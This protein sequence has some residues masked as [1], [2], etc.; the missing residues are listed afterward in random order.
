M[1]LLEHPAITDAIITSV[2][3]EEVKARN[4]SAYQRLRALI[5]SDL[6][7]FYV[8]A[9]EY[10]RDTY[11]TADPGESPNDRNDRAIRVAAAW[12]VNKI[13]SMK[14]LLLSDDAHNRT[15]AKELGVTAV[16]SHEYAAMRHKDAP[17]LIDLVAANKQADIEMLDKDSNITSSSSKQKKQ[18]QGQKIY[19]PHL[20]ISDIMMG[21]KSGR[22]HQGSLRV[23]RF[24]RYDGWVSSDSI[25]KDILI[26][27]RVSMNR[28]MDGDVVAI[29]ILPED[30]WHSMVSTGSIPG[31]DTS[32]IADTDDINDDNEDGE[33]IGRDSEVHLAPEIDV[34]ASNVDPQSNGEAARRPTG[35][36]VGIVKRNWRSRGY[37]GSLK[38]PKNDGTS[39]SFSDGSH[40]SVL[41]IPVE[42]RF[43]PIR[44]S[45][46]QAGTLADKRFI[47]VVDGW[48]E[49][50]YHPL[51]HYVRTLGC[52]GDV[53]V[54]TEVLLIENDV[55]TSPFS[56][57]VHA[58]VPPLPWTVTDR[59]IADPARE[60]LRH[61]AVCSVDPPGCKDIDDA[62]HL[63]ELPNGNYELGVH[64]A[65]VSHFV[66]PGTAMDSEAATRATTTYL[67][68]RRIDML[69]KPLTED[70][71]SLRSGMER[72]AFSVIWEITPDA[73]VLNTRFTKSVIC[74]RAALTYQEAQAR[75]DDQRLHDE[76]TVSLRAMNRVAKIMRQRRMERGALQLAS[77]EVKFEIDRETLDPLDVGM[78]QVC[79]FTV[80]SISINIS[81]YNRW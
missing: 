37:C 56:P 30:Q 28:A 16:S 27:G 55:R 7:R 61:I 51:G 25:G 54:E 9:N 42:Q 4:T 64:I 34:D 46:R 44:I 53:N 6:K 26:K 15:K 35:K 69:P 70:I 10:H 78:Y 5:S 17:D 36:V 79:G 76:V 48:E 22:F 73:L 13:P 68:Q 23:S 19:Q 1:D 58:C 74:S 43:P 29:E 21:L 45:T 49:D 14:I 66:K 40:V 33:H 60:D 81:V 62:L 52:I 77:P 12:Y 41:F 59:D 80:N 71:C 24:M 72:L 20:S 31:R 11:I 50:S 18:K 32:K 3:L 67:V 2:V 75:I 63:R 8:F 39:S 38:P 57:A 47:V 65:D